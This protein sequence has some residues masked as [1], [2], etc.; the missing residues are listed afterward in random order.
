MDVRIEKIERAKSVRSEWMLAKS[1]R[2]FD[3]K[4]EGIW[5]K[6]ERKELSGTMKTRFYTF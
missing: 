3:N 4:K 2:I 5:K 1:I 6:R